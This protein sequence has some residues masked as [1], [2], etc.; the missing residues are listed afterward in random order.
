MDTGGWE[1]RPEGISIGVS[2]GAQVAI[3]EADVI[4]FVVDAQVGA[5]S[6]DEVMVDTLRKSGK[7]VFLVA[8]KVDSPNEEA[9]AHSLWNLGLGEPHFVTALHGKGSADLLD[10][11]VAAL[12]EV[13]SALVKDNYRKVALIGRPNVGKSSLLNAISGDQLSLVDAKIGR[14]HV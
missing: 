13:G 2:A 5:Q 12:P 4:L 3:D 6:E 10:L 8:N 1:A 9:E 7:K 11:V 14:A